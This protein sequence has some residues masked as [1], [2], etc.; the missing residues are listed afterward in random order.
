MYSKELTSTILQ[1]AGTEEGRDF[2][3]KM[4]EKLKPEHFDLMTS[5][6]NIP[7]ELKDLY[8]SIMTG[9][10]DPLFKLTEKLP[11]WFRTGDIIMMAGNSHSSEILLKVQ[12][13]YYKGT[14]SSHIAILQA[15][16]IA[17]DAM[18]QLGVTT[19]LVSDILKDAKD[20]WRIIRFRNL[21]SQ[22]YEAIQKAST[23]FFLQPYLIFPGKK[24]SKKFSYC[25]ELARKIYEHSDIKKTG[26]PN[27]P[28]IK[29][30]DFDILA[31]TSKN[32]EDVTEQL[33]PAVEMVQNIS[34]VLSRFSMHYTN[35]LRLNKERFEDRKNQR[36]KIKRLQKQGE[37]AES[38]ANKYINLLNDADKNMNNTFWD[39]P[40]RK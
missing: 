16:F 21:N 20:D 40:K 9:N 4:F 37:I 26:I 1:L 23:Y 25:S 32:W 5:L 35:G 28:V 38:M 30:C 36:T 10:L 15:D 7:P 34:P 11:D 12:K 14:R 31:D 29:P 8:K 24:P 33:R 19:R 18:P 27:S 17:V 6:V 22:N 39:S 2:A 3:H 13:R